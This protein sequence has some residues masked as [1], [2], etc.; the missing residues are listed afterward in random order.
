MLA[1]TPLGK[2]AE[3]HG[4]M[5]A[6]SEHACPPAVWCIGA[7]VVDTVQLSAASLQ[8]GG[9]PV[10]MGLYSPATQIRGSVEAGTWVVAEDHA[11]LL[12]FYFAS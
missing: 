8:A 12:E 6:I 1:L 11:R 7:V 5:E 2:D 3:L 10:L 4:Q 9:Y